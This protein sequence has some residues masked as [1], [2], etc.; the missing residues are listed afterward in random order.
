MQQA[1][2]TKPENCAAAAFLQAFVEEAKKSGL[3][4]RL[5]DHHGVKGRLLVAADA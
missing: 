4:A 5:I 1:V 2:G 3:I